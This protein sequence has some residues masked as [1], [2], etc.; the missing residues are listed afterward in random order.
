MSRVAKHKTVLTIC[1]LNVFLIPHILFPP[2][3]MSET[4]LE[5]IKGRTAEHFENDKNNI[6][7]LKEGKS[8][9][10]GFASTA[11]KML[12]FAYNDKLAQEGQACPWSSN[13]TSILPF[14]YYT[15]VA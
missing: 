10:S 6:P 5:K 8:P 1:G 9:S 13:E 14:C 12:R 11:V 7:W 15:H 2:L 3:Q 4:E